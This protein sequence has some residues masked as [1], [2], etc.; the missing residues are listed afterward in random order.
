VRAKGGGRQ[1]LSVKT[2]TLIA[3]LEGVVAPATR[4]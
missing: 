2:P 3:D 4:F 1:R